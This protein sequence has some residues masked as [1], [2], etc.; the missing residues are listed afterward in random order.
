[1]TWSWWRLN[2][3]AS[4]RS[5]NRSRVGP[6]PAAAASWRATLLALVLVTALPASGQSQQVTT[7]NGVAPLRVGFMAD[8]FGN[9]D[10]TDAKA[11]VITW[12]ET[13]LNDAGI[14]TDREPIIAESL[15]E[16]IDALRQR[17][18]D[19]VTLGTTQYFMLPKGLLE[20]DVIFSN[21]HSRGAY[22]TYLILVHRD[23][24][25]TRLEDLRGRNL[26]IW[27]HARTNLALPWLDTLLDDDDLPLA[28]DFFKHMV[29]ENK[30]AKA[31]LPVFFK[32]QSACLV[33][34]SGFEDMAELNPQVREQ[35]QILAESPPVVPALFCFRAGYEP[36]FRG[37]IEDAITHIH[38]TPAGEQILTAFMCERILRRPGTCLDN[39]RRIYEMW[40]QLREGRAAPVAGAAAVSVEGKGLER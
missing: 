7:Q 17:R 35:L 9:V 12:A 18:V 13:I 1:M 38:E 8:V 11:A 24:G 30:L 29:P 19:C 26:A 16:L 39:S 36:P 21:E 22:E 23:S 4:R 20:E 10:R 34:R 27:N 28:V 6:W 14:P 15:D 33:G 31:I 5:R 25:I 40:T 2:G 32:Q 3:E 37:K